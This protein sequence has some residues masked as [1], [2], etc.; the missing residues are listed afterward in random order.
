MH[1][2]VIGAENAFV[3]CLSA[4]GQLSPDFYN[5]TCGIT[6]GRS[7]PAMVQADANCI[8][9]VFGGTGFLGRRVV[10]RLLQK[11]F[12]VRAASRHPE[13]VKDLFVSASTHPEAVK[14][15][16]T[17]TT[18]LPA[19]ELAKLF[20]KEGVARFI[21]ISGI[22]PESRSHSTYISAR[23]R[24]GEAERK[25][26]PDSTIVRPAVMVG[27]EDSFLTTIMKLIGT[28]PVYP[29]FGHGHT[30][31]QPAYVGDVAEGICALIRRGPSDGSAAFELA[32][33]QI[34]TYEAL[35]RHIA[36]LLHRPARPLP[37][38]FAV[39]TVLG[40]IGERL[41]L[42]ITRNQVDL[43]RQ[44]NV[45][46]SSQQGFSD[47]GIDVTHMVKVVARISGPDYA[48]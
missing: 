13:R 31:L 21:Q 27:P 28:L 7:A 33:P 22:G 11:S 10:P 37:V 20:R 9:T 41:S 44:D 16:I 42:P 2:S 32:G 46:D 6:V 45:A 14:A 26:F 4:T 34:Y 17:D 29:M 1:G 36:D 23:G 38:P 8:V 47:L 40:A 30:R 12:K 48:S 3:A 39:W 35:V 5:E 19:G 18:S 24:G 15:A 25:A 43:M